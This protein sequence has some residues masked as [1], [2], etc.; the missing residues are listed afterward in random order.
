LG[1]QSAAVINAVA[2]AFI[3]VLAGGLWP[4]IRAS[5]LKPVEA[6]RHV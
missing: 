1:V 4:A 2:T 6:I 5:R 3:T